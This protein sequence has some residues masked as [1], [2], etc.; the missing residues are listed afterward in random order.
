M[1]SRRKPGSICPRQERLKGGSRL[2]PGRRLFFYPL[3]LT[4]SLVKNYFTDEKLVGC[5]KEFATRW[6]IGPFASVS[7]RW[8]CHSGSAWKVFHF[9][10]RSAS[11]SHFNR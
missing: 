10:S 3:C 6:T 5:R 1:V 8:R 7:A 9:F 2:S 11:E 4:A